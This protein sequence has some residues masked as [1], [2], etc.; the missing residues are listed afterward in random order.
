V[1]GIATAVMMGIM[2][3][4]KLSKSL[5]YMPFLVLL[6]YIVYF[7]SRFVTGLLVGSPI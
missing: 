5:L 7:L 6:A 1:L 2:R 3:D 4:G